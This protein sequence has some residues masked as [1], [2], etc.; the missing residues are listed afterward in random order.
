MIELSVDTVPEQAIPETRKGSWFRSTSKK[1]KRKGAA[2]PAL[3]TLVTEEPPNTIPEVEPTVPPQN[4]GPTANDDSQPES[5]PARNNLVEPSIQISLDRVP[6]SWPLASPQPTEPQNVQGVPSKPTYLDLLSPTISISSI[7]DAVP[8]PKTSSS[9]SIPVPPQN[10]TPTIAGGIGDITTGVTGAA[11]SRFTLRL[12]LL[13]RS[14][15]PLNEAVAVAQTEDIRNLAPPLP[16]NSD[17]TTPLSVTTTEEVQRPGIPTV[18][19]NTS[20][21]NLT[22]YPRH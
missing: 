6:P 15:I 11:T 4:A 22:Y 5:P 2:E 9:V 10:P 16:H 8:Q 1:P 19:S 17:S 12:P 13:G 3:E 20:A 18:P 21:W 7:D 14:K